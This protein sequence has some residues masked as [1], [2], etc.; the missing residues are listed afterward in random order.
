M[1]ENNPIGQGGACPNN[2][3]PKNK[4]CKKVLKSKWGFFPLSIT[5]HREKEKKKRGGPEGRGHFA[6]KHAYQSMSS[7]EWMSEWSDYRV[8]FAFLC[9]FCF[10]LFWFFTNLEKK[11]TFRWK[12][13][14][15][16]FLSSKLWNNNRVPLCL[17]LFLSLLFNTN[18]KNKVLNFLL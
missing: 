16:W 12:W 1:G 15:F 8:F 13:S 10:F 6:S 4:P 18:P 14:S 5:H 2:P 17:S 7:S 3:K 11:P 9:F